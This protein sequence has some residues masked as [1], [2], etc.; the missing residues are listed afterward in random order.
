MSWCELACIFQSGIAP[1]LVSFG[2]K[3]RQITY[4]VS[5]KNGKEFERI[6]AHIVKSSRDL[7]YQERLKLV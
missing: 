7:L 2:R 4:I 3:K 5:E 6:C 1:K